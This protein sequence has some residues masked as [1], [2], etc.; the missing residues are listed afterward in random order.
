MRLTRR[1]RIL[2]TC[3]GVLVLA[4]IAFIPPGWWLR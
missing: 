4:G 2:A 3:A 1:G